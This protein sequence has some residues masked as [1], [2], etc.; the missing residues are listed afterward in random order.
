MRR[1][2]TPVNYS[3][4]LRIIHNGTLRWLKQLRFNHLARLRNL[5]I[6]LLLTCGPSNPGKLWESYKESLTEDILIKACREN[7]GLALNYTPDM[8][9]QTLIILEDK[10]LAMAGKVLKQLGL[11]TPLRTL[12]D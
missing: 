3:V 9:N 10:A 2:G 8:F 6:I 12:S 11:P 5:F 7:P 4:Y 1:F